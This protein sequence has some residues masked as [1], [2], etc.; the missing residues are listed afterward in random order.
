MKKL[1]LIL[2]AL[3]CL[4]VGQVRVIPSFELGYEKFTQSSP[5][6]WGEAVGYYSPWLIT[7]NPGVG[8]KYKGL[9]LTSEGKTY[10]GYSGKTTFDAYFVEYTTTLSYRLKRFELS[11]SHVCFHPLVVNSKGDYTMV[12]K[13]RDAI[14]LKVY[15]NEY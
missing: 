7:A 6:A 1:L 4:A 13:N 15:F 3:P 2:I 8:L 9:K 11:Y 5:D 14:T 10:F 12:V